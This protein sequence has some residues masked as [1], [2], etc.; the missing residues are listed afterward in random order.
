M[1]AALWALQKER[2]SVSVVRTGQSGPPLGGC[3]GGNTP[4]NLSGRGWREC[5]TKGRR[6]T[7]RQPQ[8]EEDTGEEGVREIKRFLWDLCLTRRDVEEKGQRQPDHGLGQTQQVSGFVSVWDCVIPSCWTVM[9]PVLVLCPSFTASCY[10]VR[11]RR[12]C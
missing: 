12:W 10:S 4:V 6:D 3:L 9:F 7:E 1:N 5:V 2:K 8:G 11:R